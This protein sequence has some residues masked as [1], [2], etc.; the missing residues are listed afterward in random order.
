[1]RETGPVVRTFV[2]VP[3]DGP[4]L[5]R[6]LAAAQAELG[7]AGGRVRWVPPH[8]FHYTLKFLGEIP[9]SRVEAARAAVAEA[10][11]GVAPFSLAV[12]GVGA[13]PRPDA[14]RV[15]WAGC[16]AGREALVALA[17]R[18]ERALVAAGFPPEPRPFSPHLTLGRVAQGG[19]TAGLA[20]AVEAARDR[21]FGTLP[22]RAVVLYRSDLRPYGPIYT[23]LAT[24]P[25]AGEPPRDR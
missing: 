17:E 2:A 23:P 11:V 10:V 24:F 5:C 15:I 21:A 8:Q 9:A 4:M 22:V 12:A 6:S 13:F 14:A 16:G 25:L 3:V 7:R 18:V 20:A 19:L 1:M